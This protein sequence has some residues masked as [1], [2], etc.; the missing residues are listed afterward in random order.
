M[1]I[2]RGDL[3]H[4]PSESRSGKK[5]A[6]RRLRTI[7]TL[8]AGLALVGLALSGCASGGDSSGTGPGKATNSATIAMPPATIVNWIW[9]FSSGATYSVVN[10]EAQQ[11]L[12]RPL[13]W[14]GD[15]NGKPLVDT[16]LSVA[17]QPTWS[18]DGMTATIT[19]KDYKWSNGETV[20]ASDVM[21]W[22]NLEKAEE[23]NWAMYSPGEF[24]DNV[25][26]VTSPDSS[27]VV[28]TFNKA[29]NQNW[30]LYNQLSQITPMPEAWDV[31]AAGVKGSCA[32]DVNSCAA[33]YNYLNAQAKNLPN[34]ASS[35]IWSVVD[36]PWR[37]TSFSSD[38]HVTFEPNK[39]Y[40]GPIKPSLSKVMF[41]PYTTDTAE[42]NVLRAGSTIDLGYI[43]T[44]DIATAKASD[45]PTSPAGANPLKNYNLEPW[46]LYSINYFPYNFNNPTVGPIFKQLYF[47]QAFQSLVDQDTIIKT[48]AKNYGVPTYGPV[49]TYPQSP[50]VGST[51][52]SNPYPF[53]ISKAK[54][55]LT[56]HGWKV[57]PNG[58]TTCVKP[59]TGSDEC[60]DGVTAGAAL[61]FNLPYASGEQTIDTAMQSLKSNASEVGIT[62]NL[63][64]QPFNTVTGNTVPCTASQ[65]T[66]AW[67]FG[68]WGG[69]WVYADDY[70]PTGEG[71]FATGAGSN[72]GSY[73]NPEADKLIQETLTQSGAAGQR[74]L[75]AY[76][77]FLAKDLP[78]V[79]QPDYTYS[80]SEI[81]S[82]LKGVTPQNVFGVWTP[83]NWKWQ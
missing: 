57:V 24:P 44:Q 7:A 63:S 3:G 27:T 17:N 18:N 45:D 69:G 71:L 76:N 72:D 14:F 4:N 58:T 29:Y 70:Y 68:N 64:P 22:F 1:S 26:S 28:F 8:G 43:P 46:Y 33:V 49:P 60:G 10:S 83:E 2:T 6:R 79:W 23:A 21:F 50:L 61:T 62:I 20:N 48:A 9:P 31:T 25:T 75:A 74:A 5:T 37:M 53:S 35:P 82:G 67:Q 19:L 80:L 54:D 34:Y 41:A 38:G 42:F 40:S 73:S 47:R 78:V 39:S 66:C 56:D 30:V 11:M 77:E 52:L 65:S 81:A 32:T 36:G 55:L 12:Y 51:Q 16:Q 13:Y 59:G 15:Q